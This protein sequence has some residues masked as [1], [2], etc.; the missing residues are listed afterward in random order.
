MSAIN[1]QQIHQLLEALE[2]LH[3][4]HVGPF[5]QRLFD[6][7]KILFK[8]C[9]HA[10][11]VFSLLDGGHHLETD[12]SFP[13]SYSQTEFFERIGELV[14]EQHPGYQ[15]LL[16]GHMDTF[17]MSDLLTQRQ[18]R[19]TDLYN[20]VFYPMDKKYQLAL[21]FV[22]QGG[23]GALTLNRRD[24]DFSESELAAAIAFAKHVGVAY[25]TDKIIQAAL[26]MKA[27]VASRDYTPWRRMGL[28]NRECEVLDWITQGKRDG[29]IAVI[30]GISQRTVNVHVHS[31]LTK[32]K[33]ENR[34]A[35]ANM[36]ATL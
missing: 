34:T 25:E 30:L 4:H 1:G 20:E 13:A 6:S 2:R 8:E 21:P 26:P 11:E 35:A 22:S 31:I 10:F 29:E 32:L 36:V 7:T 24:R 18:F 16:K 3:S 27:A 17:R 28:T 12:M 9:G 23:F 14:R 15:L 19:Q 33:V 5:H